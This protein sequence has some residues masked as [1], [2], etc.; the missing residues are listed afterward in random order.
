[1]LVML[2][3]AIAS[4]FLYTPFWE[5]SFVASYDL[6]AYPRMPISRIFIIIFG[7]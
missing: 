2:V 6:G 7:D 1:M 5:V 3:P 4:C